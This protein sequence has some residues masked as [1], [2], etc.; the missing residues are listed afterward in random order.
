MAEPAS[1][2]PHRAL[3]V[4]SFGGPEKNEDVIPFLE[5]V[6]RGRGIPRERLVEV[7]EHYF[8]M[9]GKSPITDQNR[10]IIADLESLIAERVAPLGIDLPVYFGNRNWYPFVEDTVAQMARDGVTEALVLATSAWGGYSGHAQYL[11][12]IARAEESC[13]EAGL[14]PP[15]MTKI[16]PFHDHPLFVST[17]ARLVDETRASM[18]ADQQKDARLLFTAHSIPVSADETSSADTTHRYS[19]QVLTAAREIRELSG[20]AVDGAEGADVELVWQSRSGPPHIPWLEPDICDYL[21][22]TV[23]GEGMADFSGTLTGGTTPGVDR[24]PVL[25]CPVG[26]ITDHME[27]IWDLDTEARDTAAELG[28]PLVRVPTPGFEP[29]FPRMILDLVHEHWPDVPG[30]DA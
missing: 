12:D 1:Q 17:F 23:A 5:N 3:L 9:D 4:L 29:E 21:Q 6:T 10:H 30:E 7:G 16:R 24:R 13:R 19:G 2:T 14:T 8:A 25:L 15:A 22:A 26:F 11:E 18:P 28:V 27:V 20:F